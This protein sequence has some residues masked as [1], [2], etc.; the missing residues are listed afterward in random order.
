LRH[1]NA[2]CGLGL[3]LPGMLRLAMMRGEGRG[4][5]SFRS[6]CDGNR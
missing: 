1:W 4:G 2:L 6:R 5:V 3:P